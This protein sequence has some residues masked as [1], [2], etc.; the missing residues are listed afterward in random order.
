MKIEERLHEAMHEYA[1]GIEPD[2]GSWTRI[3]ARFDETLPTVRARPSRRPLVLAGVALALVV[4]L[5]A[6][7]VVRDDGEEGRV[8]TD[9]S[10]TAA[11]PSRILAITVDGAPVVLQSKDSLRV[12]GSTGVGIGEGTQIAVL[13]NGTAA[14]VVQGDRNRGCVDTSIHRYTL[15]AEIGPAAPVVAD[16][17]KSPTVSP[18]G[19]YLAY[20]RCSPGDSR[21]REIVLRDLTTGISGGAGV[22]ETVTP[23]PTGAYFVDR[24]EFAADSRHV[25][26]RLVD[27]AVEGMHEIDIVAG[28][29]APGRALGVVFAGFG[30]VGVRGTT[31]E[32][33]ELSDASP[34]V[35][36][37]GVSASSDRRLFALPGIPTQVVSDRSGRHVLALVGDDLY[38]WSEGDR[39]PTKLVGNYIG[40]AWIP[41]GAATPPA[42]V[43]TAMPTRVVVG[44]DGRL[45]VLSS[46]DGQ[47]VNKSLGDF[48]G[49]ASL[50]ARFDASTGGHQVFFTSTGTS[51]ACGSQP[52]PDITSMYLIADPVQSDTQLRVLE[53]RRF[54]GGAQTPVIS[55][56]GKV[57]AYG[58]G[59]DGPALG[60]TQL[61]P[62]ENVR[63]EPFVD[64]RARSERVDTVDVLGW[65]GDSKQLLY[66]VWF[67]GDASPRYYVGQFR[68]AVPKSAMDVYEFVAEPNVV[69][70]T[71]VGNDTLAIATNTDR[72]GMSVVKGFP[73]RFVVEAGSSVAAPTLF[74]VPGRVTSL[75]ADPSG[76]HFLAVTDDGA[77]YRWSFGDLAATKLSEG[78]TAAAWLPD[79]PPPAAASSPDGI[80]LGFP[81]TVP[82]P[83][84]VRLRSTVSSKNPPND[85]YELTFRLEGQDPKVVAD[86]YRDVLNRSGFDVMEYHS[87]GGSDGSTTQFDAIGKKWDVAVT[88]GIVSSRDLE[89]IQVV[90]RTHGQ[91]AAER[92]VVPSTTSTTLGP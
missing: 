44:I 61:R 53:T 26:Y 18:D 58:I 8:V 25:Q 10:P 55:P 22:L 29:P 17:A 4:V 67:D 5:I 77:L 89:S 70:A 60:L 15:G 74:E 66:R 54:V 23:A 59:C 85:R 63:V 91:P 75:V 50:S 57:V 80:P 82:L 47:E 32:H 45:G 69:A 7:L 31:G 42:P 49:L 71:F 43:S 73:L 51:G 86:K 64:T 11:M 24:L 72:D 81:S 92:L 36:V 35:A 46:A 88:S 27:D 21:A 37:S 30:W 87:V 78:V 20:L 12:S 68:S 3:S 16:R 6:A 39:E 90:V 56:N 1:D 14:Y 65:S 83:E 76:D 2:A 9:P 84:G 62:T 28:E 52:G 13:P 19:R 34:G 40:A 79:P 33:F 48:T 41:D 38:R